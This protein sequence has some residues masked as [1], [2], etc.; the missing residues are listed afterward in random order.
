MPLI[1]LSHKTAAINVAAFKRTKQK[2]M[3][4]ISIIFAALQLFF[5]GS[6]GKVNK[7]FQNL[8]IDDLIPSTEAQIATQTESPWLVQ[9]S[10]KGKLCGGVL[11]SNRHVLTGE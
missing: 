1:V 6:H 7:K 10:A 2:K 3:W 9:V 8:I 4:K 5:G 11:I